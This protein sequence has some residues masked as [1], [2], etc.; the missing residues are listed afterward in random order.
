M[1]DKE[2][3]VGIVER[4]DRT[5]REVVVKNH[6]QG[7]A[8]DAK[9]C[10]YRIAQRHAEAFSSFLKNVVADQ[11]GKSL[12]AFPDGE[13]KCAGRQRVVAFLVRGP[14]AGR[15]VNRRRRGRTAA[16][17]DCNRRGQARLHHIKLRK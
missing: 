10:P 15:I 3:R 17:C 2:L 5:R 6:H 9:S 11:D 7:H 16:A 8:P 12:A 4:I 13:G 1:S 14:V